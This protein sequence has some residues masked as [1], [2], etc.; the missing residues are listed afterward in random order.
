MNVE[1]TLGNEAEWRTRTVGNSKAAAFRK[2][3]E[4]LDMSASALGTVG[5]NLRGRHLLTRPCP[6]PAD[7]C[8]EGEMGRGR[9]GTMAAVRRSSEEAQYEL[10]EIG[11]KISSSGWHDAGV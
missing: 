8:H 11:G 9:L 2:T 5:P 6:F 4:R 3:A 1:L 10:I 7:N